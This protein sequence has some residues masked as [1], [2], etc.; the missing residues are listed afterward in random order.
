MAKLKIVRQIQSQQGPA[1]LLVA[2]V[3]TDVA[4]QPGWE[5]RDHEGKAFTAEKVTLRLGDPLMVV[6]MCR[7]ER[8]TQIDIDRPQEMIV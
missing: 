6:V 8:P 2:Y 3:E 1:R 5:V 7:I 4:P